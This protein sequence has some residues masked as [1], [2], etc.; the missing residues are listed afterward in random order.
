[1]NRDDLLAKV[2][3]MNWHHR[4]DLG[5]GIVTP[6]AGATNGT[7][8]IIGV[9]TS[10]HG[11]SVIDIGA[12]DGF[13]SFEAERRGADRVLATDH[14]CWG[15]SGVFTKDGFDLAKEALNSNVEAL[16]V[17]VE[18]INPRDVGLF[19]IDLFLGV[20]YHAPGPLGYFMRV[21]S[22]TKKFAI[23]E[24]HVDLLDIERP[25]LACYPAGALGGDPTNFFGPN[26]AAVKGMCMDA[27]FSR[28]ETVG[29][30]PTRMAFHAFV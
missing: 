15:G 9:P 4:I 12:W 2:K 14:F 29:Q 5:Q 10:L 27:G 18:D 17:R 6:S 19:D 21:R 13:Y 26:E 25:A 30:S 8:Q 20:L 22:V 28:V 1:M 3:S 11:S 24:T 23:I 16:K 7:L